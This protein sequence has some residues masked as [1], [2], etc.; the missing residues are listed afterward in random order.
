MRALCGGWLGD[1]RWTCLRNVFDDDSR[2][3]HDL[4]LERDTILRLIDGVAAARENR[5]SNSDLHASRIGERLRE[6]NLVREGRLKIENL[7]GIDCRAE[8]LIA[9]C[10]QIHGLPGYTGAWGD[11][12]W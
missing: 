10:I 1:N 11:N 2:A 6:N 7:L 5:S 3:V 4:V 9:E 8:G 12:D